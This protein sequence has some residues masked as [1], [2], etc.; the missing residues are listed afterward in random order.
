[1]D[2]KYKV[3]V[4]DYKLDSKLLPG[5][6]RWADFNAS[7]HN[8]DLKM[9]DLLEA[10]YHGRAITTH[11]KDNW[12]ATQ[13][14]ICGQHIGLDFDSGEN[15]SLSCLSKDKFITRYAAFTHT[16]I[17]NTDEHPRTRV[18]FLLDQPILQAKNYGLAVSSLLWLFGTADR[19]C[20]D[21]VR[22]FYGSP[23]CEFEYYSNVLSLVVVKKLITQYKE[24]G[25]QEKKKANRP[26]YLPPATQKDVAEALS[27]INPWQVDYDE[28]VSILMAIHSEFGEAGYQLAE[29]WGDGKQ[30]EISQKWKS[31]DRDGNITGR[32]TIGTLFNIAQRFGW[33]RIN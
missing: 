18:I 19:Q 9:S 20:K 28:W 11:H 4:S 25:M 26:D 10:V 23:G 32:V 5:D 29:S 16:T 24:T 8:L 17:S 2:V 30:G 7:F 14:Y 27:K 12:R 6:T 13:N 3:A 1:M 33:G 21:P 31:F 22:F 15:T